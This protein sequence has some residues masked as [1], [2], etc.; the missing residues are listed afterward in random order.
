MIGL[1]VQ[2]LGE[3]FNS[4][5]RKAATATDESVYFVARIEKELGQ[6]GAI[7]AS[8]SCDEC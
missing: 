4:T 2:V 3:K 6:V 8:D 5:C 1:V 7:L